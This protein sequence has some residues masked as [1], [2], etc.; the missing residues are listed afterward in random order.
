MAFRISAL[1][2]FL[3]HRHTHI[4]THTYRYIDIHTHTHTHALVVQWSR[5]CFQGKGPRFDPWLRN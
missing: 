1:L 5:L 2:R 4:D 3:L